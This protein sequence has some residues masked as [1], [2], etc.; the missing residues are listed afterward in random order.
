[1]NARAGML[2]KLVGN[3]INGWMCGYA[4]VQ[5][6]INIMSSCLKDSFGERSEGSDLDNSG[7]ALPPDAPFLSMTIKVTS[8][9]HN[10]TSPPRQKTM[11]HDDQNRRYHH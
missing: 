9:K 5:M 2:T 7:A 10:P 1:M 3:E 11:K 6:I 8:S 4:D